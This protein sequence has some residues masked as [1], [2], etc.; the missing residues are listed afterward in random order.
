MKVDF[1]H[2]RAY[3]V[4]DPRL[5]GG[6][7]EETVIR[8]AA[9]GGI[10]LFQF[11]SK[12]LSKREY[13]AQATRLAAVCRELGVSLLLNDHVD[14]AA[15]VDCDGIHVGQS[16]LHPA[17]VRA[18]LGPDKTIGLSTHTVEQALAAQESGAD[19]INIGPVFATATKDTPVVPVGLEMVRAVTAVSHL[20]V[21]TMGGIKHGNAGSVVA[22]GAN[23]VA[24]VTAVTEAPDIARA[25]R[26][27]VEIVE[28][29][30]TER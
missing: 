27:L 26:E 1:D 16:D 20:P 19:Y 30:L 21:T 8:A 2:V 24:V 23:R 11:R 22:A 6:R 17:Q 10:N 18:L 12:H 29:A 5:N 9:S 7:D 13:F 14:I 4:T 25:A 15:L 3:L 28:K